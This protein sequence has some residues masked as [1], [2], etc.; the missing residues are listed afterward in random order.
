MPTLPPAA[1]AAYV[2]YPLVPSAWTRHMRT[3]RTNGYP[4][5]DVVTSDTWWSIECDTTP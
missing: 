1:V 3:D 4:T 5:D 2:A